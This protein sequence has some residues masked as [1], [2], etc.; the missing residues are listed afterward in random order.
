MMKMKLAATDGPA[1][2]TFEPG[3]VVFMLA[4]EEFITL[5]LDPSLAP[6]VEINIW[7]NGIAVWLPYPG[8]SDYIVLDSSNREMTRLW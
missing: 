1:R 7:P 2:V 4:A 5:Q 3:G 8:E 6:S